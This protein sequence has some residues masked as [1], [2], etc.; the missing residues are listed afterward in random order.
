LIMSVE[1]FRTDVIVFISDF[2]MCFTSHWPINLLIR[3]TNWPNIFVNQGQFSDPDFI[4]VTHQRENAQFADK[5]NS[6]INFCF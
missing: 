3:V 2:I 4:N 1:A 6:F 5:P